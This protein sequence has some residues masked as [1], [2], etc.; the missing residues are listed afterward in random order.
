MTCIDNYTCIETL[1]AILPMCTIGICR[2]RIF[3]NEFQ[4]SK[5]D[6]RGKHA[7][8]YA[9]QHISATYL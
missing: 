9:Q 2:L 7:I 6:T 1:G 5:A 3:F 4:Y 8:N